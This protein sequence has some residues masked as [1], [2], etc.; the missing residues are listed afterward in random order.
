MCLAARNLLADNS[1]AR[2]TKRGSMLHRAHGHHGR[3]NQCYTARSRDMAADDTGQTPR[4]NSTDY[5]AT[6]DSGSISDSAALSLRPFDNSRRHVSQSCNHQRGRGDGTARQPY[7]GNSHCAGDISARHR[8]GNNVNKDTRNAHR[9]LHAPT[10]AV[11]YCC[12]SGGGSVHGG[13]LCRRPRI[14]RKA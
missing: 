6:D 5:A 8:L 7:A 2:H 4:Q 3:R 12:R 13:Q 11:R 9:R 1:R 14:Q 10:K